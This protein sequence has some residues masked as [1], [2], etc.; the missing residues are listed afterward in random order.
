MKIIH[1][2]DNGFTKE[3]LLKHRSE[4][5]LIHLRFIQAKTKSFQKIES[6]YFFRKKISHISIPGKKY[7]NN[8]YIAIYYSN[9]S[10]YGMAENPFSR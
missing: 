9:R 8:K 10:G 4:W 7:S 5:N 6:V 1:N 2:I 3:D